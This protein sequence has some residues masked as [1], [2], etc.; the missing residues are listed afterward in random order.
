MDKKIVTVTLNPCVD[1]TI[2]I[3]EF[4]YGGTNNVLKT[5]KDISGKGINTSIV[6]K[7]LGMESIVAGFSFAEDEKNLKEFLEEKEIPGRLL[8]ITGAMRTNIKIFDDAKKVM[9]E[10]NG[11]GVWVDKKYQDEVLQMMEQLLEET[12]L[13]IV[14]GS[15][16]PGISMD[17]YGQLTEMATEKGIPVIVDASGELL[18]RAVN[19]RPYLI[20]PNVEELEKTFHISVKTE[21]EIVRAANKILEKG[22]KYVCISR[23]K[24][25]AILV[26][27][28]K[29][30]LADGLSVEVKGIQGA[31]DSMIA[32]ICYAMEQG[33]CE[34]EYLRYAIAAA[35][36]SVL[37]EGTELCEKSEMLEMVER[38]DVL[39]K[40]NQGG[41]KD[42]KV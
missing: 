33:L 11:K 13:L 41:S 27:P 20:K 42:E 9:S 36:G 28:E 31:G 34:K 16:P 23:G 14:S 40:E 8:C 35:T 5:K 7:N 10:F 19:S 32:G 21:E 4:L 25:G 29:I 1:V 26:T 22:V 6:L 2:T 15:I 18:V 30:Y 12:K 38:V 17:I 37:H 24:N 39:V 3:E